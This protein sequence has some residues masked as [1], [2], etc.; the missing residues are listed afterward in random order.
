MAPM[1]TARAGFAAAAA[2]GKIY[3]MGGAVL[4]DCSTVLTVEAYD[5]AGD[6]WIT[7]LA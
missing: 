6:F 2:N 7:G 5:P 1:P 4:S 3:A